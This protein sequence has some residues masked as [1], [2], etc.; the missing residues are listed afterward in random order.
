MTIED[1]ERRLAAFDAASEG[2]NS[3]QNIKTTASEKA[4]VFGAYTTT[5]DEDGVPLPPP[6]MTSEEREEFT[7]VLEDNGYI[8]QD[9]GVV[10]F[11][12]PQVL[13]KAT[14]KEID[15]LYLRLGETLEH[16]P[17]VAAMNFNNA[18]MKDNNLKSIVN[19]VKN[20]DIESL[21]LN[22]NDLR[23]QGILHLADIVRN[24]PN[25]QKLNCVNL[26][27]PPPTEACRALVE[28]IEA[29]TSLIKCEFEFRDIEFKDRVSAALK[30]NHLAT[31]KERRKKKKVPT[32]TLR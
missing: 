17:P 30:R 19:N 12:N 11:Q 14:R 13:V 22:T 31:F 2:L 16:L 15:A 25:L 32:A 29:S 24:T 9:I 5:T 21:C 3:L 18:L 1:T 7:T 28:A 23:H 20:S 8:D 26:L 6:P 4:T 27:N 10:S